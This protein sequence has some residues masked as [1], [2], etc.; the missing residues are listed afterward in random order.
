[1][2]IHSVLSVLVYSC[3]VCEVTLGLFAFVSIIRS[4]ISVSAVFESL[5]RKKS[6]NEYNGAD[7]LS[8]LEAFYN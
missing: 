4:I 5:R 7:V 8:D 6:Q 2:S 1:M 3:I